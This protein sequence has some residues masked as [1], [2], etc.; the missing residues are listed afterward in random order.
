M[1]YVTLTTV[2]FRMEFQ[3]SFEKVLHALLHQDVQQEYKVILSIPKKYNNFGE[4][5]IPEW[6][7]KLETLYTDKLIML[8]SDVDFG[9]IT[10]LLYP[11]LFTPMNPDDIIIVCDDDQLYESNMVSYHLKKLE[12]Y[13]DNHAICFR[14]NQPLDLRTW[15]ENGKT[16]AKFYGTHFYFPVK[17]DSYLTLPDHWHTVSYK[18]KFFK[19]D[20][21]DAEFLSMTWNNDQLLA[22]YALRHNFYYLCAAYEHETDFRPVNDMGRGANSF[23]IKEMLPFEKSSA[24]NIYTETPEHIDV[25]KNEKFSKVFTELSTK[26]PMEWN[27]PPTIGNTIRTVEETSIV[28]QEKYIPDDPIIVSL[29]T[30]PS[31]LMND[32]SIQSALKSIL[33]QSGIEYEVHWN[34]PYSYQQVAIQLPEWL[35]EWQKKYSHLKVFRCADFGPITKIYPT[36]QRVINLNTVIISADDDLIY[37]DG[38]IT[39]HLKGI[40]KYPDCA[41]GFAGVTSI[42]DDVI[43]RYH[44]ASTQPED[45][46]VRM[47]EG[48]KTISYRKHFFTEELDQFV[49]SH[50]NDDV[51]ISAYLGYK[52]IKKMVLT[53]ENCID[54]TPRAESFPVISHVPLESSGCN[55]FRRSDT[56]VKSG[57]VVADEWYKLGYLER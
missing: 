19:D 1:I 51:A 21:F 12:Q 22:H 31:R 13:P 25:W 14:G 54:F 50:W 36:I 5:T 49:F 32:P 37:D 27:V 23:P 30:V 18:R 8:Q 17:Q 52:N 34:I 41:I 28:K 44:F 56:V 35:P 6:L 57:D 42:E 2:P 39:A 29:T 4:T 48:Y 10:N 9:P 3:E 47:L 38:F 20:I 26:P 45:V 24:Y 55:V 53:C 15:V 40:K 43:G 7:I 33:E 16:W 11:L 46:R